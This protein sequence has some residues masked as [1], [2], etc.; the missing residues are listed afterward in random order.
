[1]ACRCY[2]TG[3]AAPEY[4]G[5]T[6]NSSPSRRFTNPTKLIHSQRVIKFI[7]NAR[8]N[9]FSNLIGQIYIPNNSTCKQ[10]RVDRIFR[11]RSQLWSH[12]YSA[13]NA[14]AKRNRAT[15]HMAMP[16][17]CSAGRLLGEG[18]EGSE[19]TE[20]YNRYAN[21]FKEMNLFNDLFWSA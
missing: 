16:Q 12:I 19:A 5:T 11:K 2:T 7:L 6:G 17:C 18:C 13:L 20:P 10:N 3:S 14:G 9:S 15:C 4:I 1:M 21:L 8:I